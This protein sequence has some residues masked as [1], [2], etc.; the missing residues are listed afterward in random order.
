[1][2]IHSKDGVSGQTKLERISELS[3][4]NKD[5]VFNNLGHL[6]N[7]TLLKELF[8]RLDGNKAVGI[9][10]VTKANYGKCLDE[11]LANLLK[12]IRRNTYRPQ[13]ARLVEIPKADG[14]SRPL[15]IS[16]LEDKLVQSAV[17]LILTK[18]YEPLFL[19]YS[20]G[21]R[22]NKNCHDALRSLSKTTYQFWYGAVA[23]IDLRKCFDTIPHGKLLDCLQ[24][25]ISDKRFLRL[26]SCLLKTPIIK[27]EQITVNEIG[28]PQGSILSP[29]LSSIYLHEVVDSWF[30]EISKTHFKGKAEMVRYC[31]DMVFI[32]QRQDDAARFYQV[33]PKRLGKYGLTLHTEKSRLIQSGHMLAMRANQQGKRLPTYQFLGFTCYWGRARNGYWRLKYTSRRDRFTEKLKGL[34][35]FLQKQLNTTD[36]TAVLNTVVRVLRGWINYHGISD[37]DKR[38]KGFIHKSRRILLCWF[39]RRG[40]K[41]PMN[42][43][44]FMK[45]M[46][47]IN[48]PER[49]KTVSMF[50]YS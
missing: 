26:I 45:I 17:N 32:F 41:N 42:W 50:N 24:K 19:P 38:V 27:G 43:V 35:K 20:Y 47:K 44:T 31:D 1:M 49:W 21:F 5:L 15:A 10:N 13:P 39:N 33:L 7:V 16:C 2:T 4:Q 22:A 36:T 25:K 12:R 11:N 18:I 48:F 37:N 8:H 30:S 46:K 28:C 23:E 3:A 9:D 6:L 29:T 40:R 34:R 14:S